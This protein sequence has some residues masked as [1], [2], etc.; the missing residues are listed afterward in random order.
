MAGIGLPELGVGGEPLPSAPFVTAEPNFQVP[1]RPGLGAPARDLG[2]SAPPPQMAPVLVQLRASGGRNR[3]T[4]PKHSGPIFV[5]PPAGPQLSC[6]P[7]QRQSSGEALRLPAAH[8]GPGR[9][10][11]LGPRLVLRGRD[12]V[13][14]RARSGS[15]AHSP[16][17]KVSAV[18]P[19]ST[20]SLQVCLRNSRERSRN[21]GFCS[22]KLRP[23][24]GR[25]RP[26]TSAPRPNSAP[27][28]Q[29]R[30]SSSHFRANLWRSNFG[31][32]TDFP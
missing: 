1:G 31:P 3:P 16:R 2:S 18:Q 24:F 10:A 13:T 27:N 8:E 5:R 15:G 6:P 19:P 22:T 12:G 23:Y 26:P 25:D 9:H 17:R 20:E 7:P 30:A 11:E 4:P 32:A 29:L 21:C 28:Y 14:R